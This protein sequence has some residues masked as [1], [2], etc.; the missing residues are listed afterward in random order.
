MNANVSTLLAEAIAVIERAA[1][2]GDGRAAEI[3][4]FYRARERSPALDLS[5]ALK[6]VEELEAQGAGCHAVATVARET[7]PDN[8]RRRLN[9]ER[10]L[11]RKRKFSD[12]R[13]SEN[14]T[15]VTHGT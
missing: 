3:L 11:R 14:Q 1:G 13:V 2:D 12:R 9:L 5:A 15:G 10:Q 8:D 4:G 7:W 6:R